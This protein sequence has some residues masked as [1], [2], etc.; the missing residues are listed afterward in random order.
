MSLSREL[1]EVYE[2]VRLL[3]NAVVE[4]RDEDVLR[5]YFYEKG[6]LDY[7]DKLMEA[8]GAI[9]KDRSAS[10][11][12]MVLLSTF[13]DPFNEEVTRDEKGDAGEDTS[14]DEEPR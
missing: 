7:R 14:G 10:E 5:R 1:Y 13:P 2:R 8:M 6:A 11:A 4:E 12:F 3:E 9:P